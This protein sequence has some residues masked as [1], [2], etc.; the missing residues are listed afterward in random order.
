MTIVLEKPPV[1]TTDAFNLAE[2][3]WASM[4]A[5]VAPWQKT[6]TSGSAPGRPSNVTSGRPYRSGNSLYLM[7]VAM[8]NGWSNKWISFIEA[9]KL[10]GSLK[11]QKGTKIEVPLMRKGVDE[12]TGEEKEFLRG[13]RPATVFNLSQVAGIDF[14]EPVPQNPIESVEAVER[15]LSSLKSQGLTYLEPSYDGGCWYQ[16]NADRIGMPHRGC[17]RDSYEFYS[18]LTHELAHSTEKEGRVDRPEISYAYEELR[19]EIAATL[20][21]CTLNLPRTQAQIDNH[22]A[23]LKCWLKD[24]EEQKQMLLKAASEAQQIHDYLIGLSSQ[25]A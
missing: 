15:M 4:E 9:N 25:E 2:T 3:L 12:S 20:I 7:L 16:P 19:A 1:P 6:W 22:A 18:A 5:G 8:K 10:G 23:Y 13:F 11:G 21:C 14:S 24:F 17:F